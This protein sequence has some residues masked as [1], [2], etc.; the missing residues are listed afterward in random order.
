M[1]RIIANPLRAKTKMKWAAL[2]T[3]FKEMPEN[4]EIKINNITYILI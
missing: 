2:G 4:L 3:K 1:I